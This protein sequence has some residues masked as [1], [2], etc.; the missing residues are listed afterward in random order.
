MN[1][2]KNRLCW[3]ALGIWF[4]LSPLSAADLVV[5]IGGMSSYKGQLVVALYQSGEAFPVKNVSGYTQTKRVTS[6]REKVMFIGLR[7]GDYAVVVYHDENNNHQFDENFLG[8]PQERF[9][10]SNNAKPSTFAPPT[11]EQAKFTLKVV[12]VINIQLMSW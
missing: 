8:V 9:G 5:K 7:P 2:L 10:F 3:G 6:S 4:W 12:K 1:D 11:F